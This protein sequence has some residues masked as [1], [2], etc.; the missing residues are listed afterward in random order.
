MRLFQ[1]ALKYC[2]F[3]S[4]LGTGVF[5]IAQLAL[6]Y[7]QYKQW[8]VN[9]YQRDQILISPQVVQSSDIALQNI[10]SFPAFVSKAFTP[11]S[12]GSFAIDIPAISVSG[13][14]IVV[15]SN[16]FQYAGAHLPGT[17]LPGERGNV[18]ITAHSSL[19]Q[20]DKLTEAKAY[21]SNLPQVQKGDLVIVHAGN[22]EYNYVV[23]GLRIV[24]PSEISVINPPDSTGRYLSLM[25]CVPPGF[26][27]KRLVVLAKL[28]E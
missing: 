2:V 12:Y 17:A 19:P 21:F 11:S 4:L 15:N 22:S 25:T 1:A 16:D 27:T 24:D 28:K 3:L 20:L 18:F 26:N 14:K 9:A 8:E 7:I 23:T 5:L 10:G 6:P 13:L